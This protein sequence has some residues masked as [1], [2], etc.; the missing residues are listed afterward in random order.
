MAPRILNVLGS[1]TDIQQRVYTVFGGI[2]SILFKDQRGANY[3][4]G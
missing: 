4:S 2:Y 3:E 1:K